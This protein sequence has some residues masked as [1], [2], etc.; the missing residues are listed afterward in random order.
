MPRLILIV[1]GVAKI[2]LLCIIACLF[3]SKRNWMKFKMLLYTLLEVYTVPVLFLSF[4]CWFVQVGRGGGGSRVCTISKLKFINMRHFWVLKIYLYYCYLAMT[5][6]FFEQ[7]FL[8]RSLQITPDS[9]PPPPRT[10]SPIFCDTSTPLQDTDQPDP[11][12]LV[13]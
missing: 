6:L 12:K 9:M 2:W 4:C 1:C 5:E 8:F 10:P 11:R 7:Q 3:S 13:Y